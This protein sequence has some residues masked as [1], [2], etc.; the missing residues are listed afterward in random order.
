MCMYLMSMYTDMHT[1][2]QRLNMF[3]VVKFRSNSWFVE[4]SPGKRTREINQNGR[5][6]VFTILTYCTCPRA[7]FQD[8]QTQNCVNRSLGLCWASHSG[9]WFEPC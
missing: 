8:V 9:C 7:S 3:P 2:A 4:Y 6:P 5:F 1:C